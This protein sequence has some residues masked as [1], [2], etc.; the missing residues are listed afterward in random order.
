MNSTESSLHS[1]VQSVF[2]K[3]IKDAAFRALALQDAPEALRAVG[4]PELP[5][6]ISICFT[7]P[8]QPASLE[9]PNFVFPLPP[10]ADQ[11]LSENDLEAVTGGTG[12]NIMDV[13]SKV[14]PTLPPPPR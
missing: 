11:E 3:S 12:R 2:D 4:L 5:A 10:T 6:G 1:A 9:A 8:N 14:F 13:F 7:E